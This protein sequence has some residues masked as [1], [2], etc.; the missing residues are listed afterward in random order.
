ML[1]CRD[2]A[3]IH[4]IHTSIRPS[5]YYYPYI[6][7]VYVSCYP[8][9][10]FTHSIAWWRIPALSLTCIIGLRL[11]DEFSSFS[12]LCFFP[13]RKS[14]GRTKDLLWHWCDQT[15]R[16]F[17]PCSFYFDIRVESAG[18]WRGGVVEVLQ[19]SCVRLVFVY[20]LVGGGGGKNWWGGHHPCEMGR[21]DHN[22]GHSPV[23]FRARKS[24]RKRRERTRI[25]LYTGGEERAFVISGKEFCLCMRRGEVD[26]LEGET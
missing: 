11:H 2:G 12:D 6:F 13:K 22:K 23:R 16:N 8:V 9:T 10:P 14:T 15:G 5:Y 24:E 18:T 26:S 3:S 4:S 21:A 25:A 20:L 7:L 17:F 1:A 19:G